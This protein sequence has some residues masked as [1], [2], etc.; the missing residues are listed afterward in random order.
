VLRWALG[1]LLIMATI[2]GLILGVLNPDPV[3]LDLGFS[4]LSLSLGALM[5]LAIGLGL[6]FGLILGPLIF[7]RSKPKSAGE[8]S[9]STIVTERNSSLNG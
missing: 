9:S 1:L 8:H 4:Q 6:V 2:A 3:T 5:A 7:T